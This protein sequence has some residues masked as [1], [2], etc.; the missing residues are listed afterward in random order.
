MSACFQRNALDFSG[1]QLGEVIAAAT[2]LLASTVIAEQSGEELVLCGQTHLLTNDSLM[3]SFKRTKLVY[4]LGFISVVGAFIPLVCI[5]QV[6]L[7]D[8]SALL[9]RS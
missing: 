7:W 1:C 4:N 6:Y 9:R 2:Q 5:H 8:C 3:W